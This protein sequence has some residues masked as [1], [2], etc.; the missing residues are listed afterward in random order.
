MDFL[1]EKTFNRI[2]IKCEEDPEYRNFLIALVTLFFVLFL[3][4]GA[5]LATLG[6]ELYGRLMLFAL[7]A[8]L[9]LV[10]IPIGFFCGLLNPSSRWPAEDDDEFGHRPRRYGDDMV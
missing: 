9:M 3:F 6:L 8:V 4:A 2:R 7:A 1:L 10:M 5:F